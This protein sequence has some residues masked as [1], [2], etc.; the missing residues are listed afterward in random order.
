MEDK[1][2]ANLKSIRERNKNQEQN[3]KKIWRLVLVDQYPTNGGSEGGGD[4]GALQETENE[5]KEISKKFRR[6]DE[7]PV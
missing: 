7:F 5:W 4:G 6:T 2:D 3:R 1:V